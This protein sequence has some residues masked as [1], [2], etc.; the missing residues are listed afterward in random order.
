MHIISEQPR[1]KHRGWH[2]RSFPA[3]LLLTAAVWVVVA[4]SDVRDYPLHVR[5]SMSGFD[6]KRYAVVD[7]DTAVTFQVQTNGFSALALSLRRKPVELP[8]EMSGEPV[9]IYQR[10]TS[11][12]GAPLQCRTM[13]VSDLAE[14]LLG[15][16][17]HY[18]IRTATSQRDSLR[19][20]LAPRASKTLP[21]DISTLQVAFADGYGLY[22]EP[23]VK[24]AEVTL[25]GPHQ[26]LDRISSLR[27]AP[28][29]IANLNVT[30]A[31]R[32]PLD[33]LWEQQGDVAASVSHVE[34]TIPVQPYVERSLSLPIAVVPADSSLRLRLYP[35]HATVSLWVPRDELSSI[36]PANFTLTVDR[37][38]ILAS[39][40][41]LAPR[42]ARF[43][44]HVRV[45]AI[46]PAEVQYVII[47]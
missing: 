28:A 25:Y 18:A 34:V 26:A 10:P 44:E 40:S 30:T 31:H 6:A 37:A 21:V 20:L 3:I 46:H 38:D 11:A 35:D 41:P 23:T 15:Q 42:L 9:Q 22:G 13:A 29:A 5:L 4:M 43:P 39:R 2:M 16:L 1:R 7:A 47:Q 32:L 36:S 14:A 17:A 33:P 12:D 27:L 8:V 19:L 24:P 45:R